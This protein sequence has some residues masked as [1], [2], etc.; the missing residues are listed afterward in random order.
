MNSERCGQFYSFVC[1]PERSEGSTRAESPTRAMPR[2]L[3]CAQDD[4]P[5]RKN[6]KDRGD[7]ACGSLLRAFVIVQ[8]PAE[9]AL[10]RLRQDVRRVRCVHDHMVL[11]TVL[12]DVAQQLLQLRH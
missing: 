7:N 10:A 9:V 11:E 2:I 1:H 4:N 6:L 8:L 5:W 12:A 3:R